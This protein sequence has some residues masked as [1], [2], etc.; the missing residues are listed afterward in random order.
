MAE[1]FTSTPEN[2]GMAE[3]LFWD[4][5]IEAV[6]MLS[7]AS[8]MLVEQG[9]DFGEVDFVETLESLKE[10]TEEDA[11][12]LLFNYVVMLSAAKGQPVD[13]SEVEAF[14]AENGLVDIE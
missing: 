14:L 4:K 2:E 8:R 13:L 12:M 9:E 6:A 11:L 7:E 5:V 10:E 1:I 3:R